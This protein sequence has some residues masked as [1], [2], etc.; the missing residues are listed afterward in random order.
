MPDVLFKKINIIIKKDIKDFFF[1]QHFFLYL[2]AV[3]ELKGGN[4]GIGD[5]VIDIFFWQ[6][7][8]D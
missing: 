4:E 7:K 6:L 5:Q 3:V 8:H 2:K 1:S